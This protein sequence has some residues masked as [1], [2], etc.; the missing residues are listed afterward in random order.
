[1]QLAMLVPPSPGGSDAGSRLLDA[2]VTDAQKRDGAS[3]IECELR[4]FLF[5]HRANAHN[6]FVSR[7]ASQIGSR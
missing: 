5:S 7:L 4:K 2:R 6:F 1:M 3:H